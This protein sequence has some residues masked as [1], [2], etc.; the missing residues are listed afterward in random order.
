[1]RSETTSDSSWRGPVWGLALFLAGARALASTITVNSAA[2]VAANDGLCTLKEA[3]IA[4]NTNKASGAAAGECAAGSAGL[5]IIQF[6]VSGAGCSGGVCTIAPNNVLPEITEPAILDA[7]TQPGYAGIPRIRIN[8]GGGTLP[9]VSTMN[10]GAG[11]T[12]ANDAIV[13][14]GPSG[15]IIVHVDQSSGTVHFIVDVNGYL[16]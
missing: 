1:M 4:A 8:T 5:D 14:L 7:T 15:D 11:Q 13:P 3:I 9:V 16:Q 12:R 2:D 10:Y 6:N